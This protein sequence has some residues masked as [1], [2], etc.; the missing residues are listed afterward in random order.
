EQF[1][2][3]LDMSHEALAGH[4]MGGH[5]ALMLALRNPQRYRAAAALSPICAPTDVPWGEKAFTAY[6]GEDRAT[7]QDYDASVLLAGAGP[8]VPPLCIEQGEA[9][10]FL[11][12][13]LRPERLAAAAHATGAAVEINRRPGY[14]H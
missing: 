6:L 11:A 2:D 3:R 13:Q 9:D 8:D 14:D 7:W 1:D 4:S 10:G 5:G 12:E